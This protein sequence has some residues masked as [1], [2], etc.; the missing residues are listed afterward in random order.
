[1]K[2][3]IHIHH[4]LN[5]EEKVLTTSFASSFSAHPFITYGSL[6][7]TQITESMPLALNFSMLFL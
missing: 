7:A 1:M 3:E 5:L 6:T 4:K 2:V